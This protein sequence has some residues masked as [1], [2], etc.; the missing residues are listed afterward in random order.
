[1]HRSLILAP[2][3]PRSRRASGALLISFCGTLAFSTAGATVAK[4]EICRLVNLRVAARGIL[5]GFSPKI[6]RMDGSRIREVRAGD[7]PEL[8]AMQ[9]LLWPDASPEELRSEVEAAVDGR[10]TSTLPGIVLVAESES[11]TGEAERL[12]GFVAAGLRSH[13]D[14]CDTARPVGF[15]EGWFVREPFRGRGIGRAL[16]NAAEVWARAQ[17]CREM[18]SDALIDNLPSQQAHQ[19]L[20]FEVVDRC[21]HFRKNL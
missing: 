3:T 2:A 14:G 12:T 1:M 4:P 11:G 6:V 20:G 16:A 5:H 19:A 18:A 13:A 21:V 7:A 9:A 17:G 15:I 8:V 10:I